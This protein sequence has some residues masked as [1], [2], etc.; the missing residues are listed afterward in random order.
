MQEKA[1]KIKDTFNGN[2]DSIKIRVNKKSHKGWWIVTYI[3]LVLWITGFHYYG[4]D[5]RKSYE[6]FFL[7][8]KTVLA[9]EELTRDKWF[10]T[11]EKVVECFFHNEIEKS[12]RDVS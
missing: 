1:N 6:V 10:R 11:N 5:K 9:C 3:F 8:E 7:G 12:S 2:E 4:E